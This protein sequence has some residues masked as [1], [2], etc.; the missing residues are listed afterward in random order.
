[1]VGNKII[2]NSSVLE[3]SFFRAQQEQINPSSEPGLFRDLFTSIL[4]ERIQRAVVVSV[5]EKDT[6]I[7]VSYN[8]IDE[9]LNLRIEYFINQVGSVEALEKEMGLSL[10]E[11]KSKYWEEIKEELLV[12]SFQR[13]LFGGV[14]VSRD[15]VSVFYKNKKNTIP[16][17][18]SS[19]SFSLVEKKTTLSKKS[20]SSLLF[21][22]NSLRD[23][24]VDGFVDFGEV[25]RKRSLDPSS[26]NN[27]GK[28]TSV[29][30]DLV[31]EYEKVSFSLGVGEISSPVLTKY[32]YH[33]IKLLDVVGE[34]TT[35]QHILFEKKAS[36]DDFSRSSLF[37]DSL[38][39][40][41]LNDP[42]L[43]DSLAYAYKS[44]ESLSGFYENVN[45]SL[46]P[47]EVE[48]LFLNTENH[49]FSDIV[50]FNSSS[51][52]LYR[53]SFKKESR[54]VL[55][56]DWGLIEQLALEQKRLTLFNLWI[57]EQYN[58]VYVKINPIY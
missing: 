25:A 4:K 30:G 39:V 32:G 38:K 22:I 36:E 13:S 54:S 3:E 35:T 18:P 26:V 52:L 1:M 19:A 53:Y 33:L 2:L 17:N 57:E 5:A 16:L 12:S 46:F 49:S 21:S 48:T 43:F 40:F 31:P 44:K 14:S 42:G 7:S 9:N 58:E 41:S 27:L 24:L 29:R 11:I 37:L 6:S 8:E 28:I 50:K 10:D 45:L 51:F 56:E 55:E 20:L 23:S 34:K 15:E 47:K